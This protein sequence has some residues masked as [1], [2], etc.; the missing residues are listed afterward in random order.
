MHPLSRRASPALL[1]TPIVIRIGVEGVTLTLVSRGSLRL[2]YYE[3][4]SESIRKG[5]KMEYRGE[6]KGKNK[7]GMKKEK[8]GEGD[9]SHLT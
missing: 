6:W 1:Q 9:A 7:G 3:W 5:G 2:D 4:K 8:N